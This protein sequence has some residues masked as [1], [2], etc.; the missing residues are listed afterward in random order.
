MAENDNAKPEA[1]PRALRLRYPATC[2]SCG[3]ELPKGTEAWWRAGPKTAECQAC[4]VASDASEGVQVTSMDPSAGHEPGP[5]AAAVTAVDVPAPSERPETAAGASAQREYERRAARE[6]ARQE[7]AIERDAQQRA[8]R[9]EARPVL[10]RVLNALVERPPDPKESQPTEA[11]KIGAAGERRVAEILDGTG[12]YVLHDRRVPRSK[13]NID[14]LAVGPA[15]VF[16]IDA[17]KYENKQIEVRDKGSLF[18]AD[19][20]L[21]V[22]GRD[23]T[24][25]INGVLWQVDVVVAALEGRAAKT[26]AVLCF[27]GARWPGV[28]TNKP[29]RIRD[30]TSTYPG[31][32]AKLVAQQGPLST[33]EIEE[34]GE[35][36]SA[37]LPPA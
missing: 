30:V 13:A 33:G 12:C 11:W 27:V 20:R 1:K 21:Y 2:C 17:K 34:I 19:P 22:G 9:R 10:G 28:F 6:R 16:V 7:A 36:L 29:V 25:L 18:S 26:H 8:A 31:A 35:H 23:Q 15:G 5:F 4:H 14:H 37:R 24:K 3:T 32:L